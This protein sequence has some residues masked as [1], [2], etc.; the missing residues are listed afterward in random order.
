MTSQCL[1]QRIETLEK[2]RFELAAWENK[3]NANTAKINW[4]FKIGAA[5]EKLILLYPVT[6][7]D[8]E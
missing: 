8:V 4:H 5:R 2:L 1:S 3:R 7:N 6:A